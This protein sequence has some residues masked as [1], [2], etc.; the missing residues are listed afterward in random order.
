MAPTVPMQASG[1]STVSRRGDWTV[2]EYDSVSST[3]LVAA[4]LKHW[5]AV[6]ANTQTQGRG[7]FQRAWISDQGGLWLSAVVPF[8]EG[9]LARRALPLAAGLAVCLCLQ[10]LGVGSIRMRWPNDLLVN[11][12]KLAGLLIDQ[13]VSGSVVVGIG[14][15]VQNRPED[16][17]PALAHQTVRLADLL[18][19]P[20]DL[21]TLTALILDQVQRA[22]IE[23]AQ[24]GA[25]ALF[26][27]VNQLWGSPRAVELDLNGTLRR[28]IFKG[29]DS[30]GKLILADPSG[31]P[32]AFEAHEVRHLTEMECLS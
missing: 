24:N 29:V 7:R 28:G 21:T 31:K 11:D 4:A 8:D 3:N 25:P 19:H 13:F 26:L 5:T 2:H 23:F 27:R 9:E 6:R 22:V 12:R 16:C 20:P 15:N 30:D 14:M 1:A 10:Q 17:D 32:A 18:A